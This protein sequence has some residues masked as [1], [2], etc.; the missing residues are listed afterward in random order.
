M[1]AGVADG[2]DP[3]GVPRD[4]LD[5]SWDLAPCGE[6]LDDPKC[7]VSAFRVAVRVRLETA[8]VAPGGR[9][10]L[11]SHRR[12]RRLGGGVNVVSGLDVDPNCWFDDV[13]AQAKCQS[14][15]RA[16]RRRSP[17]SGAIQ[18]C[19]STLG[20]CSCWSGASLPRTGRRGHLSRA[21]TPAA[22]LSRRCADASLIALTTST[23]ERCRGP[24]T[25]GYRGA[26]DA[27]GAPVKPGTH[28]F[29]WRNTLRVIVAAHPFFVRAASE[30]ERR[31]E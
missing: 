10:A 22:T 4:A 17:R 24:R 27:R 13:H 28:G 26:H 8:P 21:T 31:S 5:T 6:R 30:K 19:W 2:G 16:E 14:P 1:L 20:G 15:R 9:A 7:L 23:G 11:A 29:H 18:T 12:Q 25:S 3:K